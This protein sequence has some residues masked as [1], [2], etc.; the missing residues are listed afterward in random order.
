MRVTLNGYVISSDD[1]WLYDYFGIPAFSPAV[2]R[3]AVAENP[4]GEP[5][6][7]EVNSYGG[8]VYAGFEIYSVIRGAKCQTVA[9][10][11]SLAASAASTVTSACDQVL[12]SPVAQ[13]MI[14]LPSTYTEGNQGPHR[15]SLRMLDGVTA[16]ILN[17]YEAKCGDKTSRATLEAMME[18]ETWLTAQEAVDAG[19]ADGILGDWSGV[20]VPSNV[21][22]SMGSGI[23]A[24]AQ[25]GMD[26]D[27]TELRAKYQ[28]LV[29]AGLATVPITSAPPPTAGATPTLNDD[30][31]AKARLSL[32]KNRFG[33]CKHA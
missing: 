22:N 12:M 13:L 31:Q 30:W 4:Q 26:P 24:L 6:V 21:L 20:T 3:K 2:V 18:T 5:L 17:G 1:Q 25:G 14:H 33:G 11:Q 32:A 19:L 8:S 15:N 27:P 10:V 7:L 23:R 29:E 28:Q 16:S 9:E